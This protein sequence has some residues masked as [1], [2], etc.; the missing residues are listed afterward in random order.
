MVVQLSDIPLGP[1]AST[2]VTLWRTPK[3]GTWHGSADCSALN[4][5]KPVSEDF[6]QPAEG[7]LC[8]RTWPI[9][10]HCESSADADPYLRSATA[11]V[12]F[13]ADVESVRQQIAS[14][15]LPISVFERRW[16][17][18]QPI[19]NLIGIQPL[20]DLWTI[21]ENEHLRLRERI[22]RDLVTRGSRLAITTLA[23]WV[24][25]GKTKR[26]HQERYASFLFDAVAAHDANN[27]GSNGSTR[28]YVNDRILPTWLS[29]VS[30]GGAPDSVMK[31]IVVAEIDRSV[32]IGSKSPDNSLASLISKTL[33]EVGEIWS[34][35]LESMSMAH[36]SDVLAFF[37]RYSTNHHQDLVDT[38]LSINGGAELQ[39]GGID[40]VVA[41]VPSA[42][43]LQLAEFESGR[44]GIVL[45][46]SETH[47]MGSETCARFLRNLLVELGYPAAA[48]RVI[49]RPE[50]EPMYPRESDDESNVEVPQWP[51]D[52]FSSFINS[53]GISIVDCA[54]PLRLAINGIDSTPR[55]TSKVRK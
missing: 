11:L 21:A 13:S 47:M 15:K 45:L 12:K 19:E 43:R 33:T 27:L 54:M 34:Q 35:K 23:Q 30:D 26:E 46:E 1:I 42:F 17:R 38:Y 49:E 39:L 20:L 3:G 9:H 22:A 50:L 52:G 25:A 16:N 48:Q 36:P 18:P 8:D 2:V 37:H 14:G 4:R 40:W 55:K 32:R 7:S 6:L 10:I 29:E 24:L 51:R 41:R 31:S 28:S 53:R 44:V 5:S